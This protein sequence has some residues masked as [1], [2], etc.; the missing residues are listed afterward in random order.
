MPEEKKNIY[1]TMHKQFVKEDIEYTD[2][3]T[4]ETKT[5]N[6]VT[7]PKGTTI[8]GQDVSYFQFSPLFVNESKYRG[9]NYR[10]IPLLANREIWMHKDQLDEQGKPVID[11]DGKT[12]RET[13]KVMPAQLKESL[14]AQRRGYLS[15][16]AAVAREGANALA[17][18]DIPFD[19]PA[20]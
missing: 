4:G 10:D 14:D 19:K 7:L 13:V 16:R 1:I 3:S 6:S 18:H 20:R 12:V 17:D 5:F 11:E 15:E 2:K 9:E 8:D